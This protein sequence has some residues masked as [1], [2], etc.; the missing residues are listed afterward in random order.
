M[1]DPLALLGA[2]TGSTALAWEVAVG[3][4]D[5]A[6]LNV[7]GSL[8]VRI[9]GP[10]LCNLMVAN[11]GRQPVTVVEV[12]LRHAAPL[13]IEN[14]RTG[15]I[16]EVY[17]SIAHKGVATV[18][19]GEAVPVTLALAEWPLGAVADTPFW[20]YATDFRGR[21]HFGPPISFRS[22][23]SR[24]WSFPSSDTGG[25]RHDLP[26][27]PILIKPPEP[28]WKVWLWK[29]AAYRHGAVRTGT[30]ERRW[31]ARPFG[32]LRARRW[33]AGPPPSTPATLSP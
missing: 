26:D 10:L 30:T 13:Q 27:E 16:S 3:V 20:I 22:A 2:V 21:T 12:G 18:G 8:E 31:F 29:K 33:A 11:H 24:G 9:E 5:R 28:P 17:P 25:D 4:R 19:P 14:E 7:N 23:I 6:A 32:G 15:R 1:S